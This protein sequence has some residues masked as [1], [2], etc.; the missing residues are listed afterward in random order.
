MAQNLSLPAESGRSWKTKRMAAFSADLH[1]IDALNCK[2]AFGQTWKSVCYEQVFLLQEDEQQMA[3][4][5]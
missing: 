5:A 2:T 3:Q 4:G 1:R